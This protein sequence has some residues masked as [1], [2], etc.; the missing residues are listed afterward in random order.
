[1]CVFAIPTDTF[2]DGDDANLQV[3]VTLGFNGR[4]KQ[5]T[6]IPVHVAVTN[7]STAEFKGQLVLE[8]PDGEGIVVRFVD[9]HLQ[10]TVPP[11]TTVTRTA[12]VKIGRLPWNVEVSVVDDTSQQTVFKETLGRLDDGQLSTTDF[13]ILQIGSRLPL[14]ASR[15]QAELTGR[16]DLVEVAIQSQTSDYHK[17]PDRW[18]GY[19]AVDL[20]I[21]TTSAEELLEQLSVQQQQAIRQWIYQGGRMLLFAGQRGPEL[22]SDN[23]V[24]GSLIPGKIDRVI[25]NWNTSGIEK[26]GNAD[27]R[28]ILSRQPGSSL[29]LITPADGVVLLRDTQNAQA[30]HALIVHSARGLG[31][32]TFAAFDPDQEPFASWGATPVILNRL[33]I[34]SH[35]AERGNEQVGKGFKSSNAGFD[36]ISGQLRSSLD[37]FDGVT[38]TRFMWVAGLLGMFILVIGPLDYYILR[39]FKRLHWT[40]GTFPVAILIFSLIAVSMVSALRT[41]PPALNQIEIVDIDSLTQTVRGSNYATVYSPTIAAYSF[42]MSEF[43]D[44]MRSENHQVLA[45]WQGFPGAGLGGLGRASFQVL[46]DHHYEV[47][48]TDGQIRSVPVQHSGTR[49]LVARWSADSSLV[50]KSALVTE[51]AS[52]A[53]RGTLQNPFDFDL[54]EALILFDG[55]VY[56][57]GKVFTANSEVNVYDLSA[58]SQGIDNYFTRFQS[59]SRRQNHRVWRATDE[60]L[61]RVVKQM[62]FNQEIGGVRYTGLLHRYQS[63]LDLSHLLRLRRAVLVGKAGN[64]RG[65]TEFVSGSQQDAGAPMSSQVDR[66]YRVVLPVNME[67]RSNTLLN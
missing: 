45:C 27:E 25:T 54:D 49:S 17:L 59:G 58:D 9:R 36:D 40:W 67:A 3:E 41:S 15:L 53:L 14:S 51:P 29:S 44:S 39:R 56:P 47:D 28:L 23:E 46:I 55:R 20:L 4:F 32:V 5:G 34:N 38:P 16:P 57:L 31:A 64:R 13:L 37:R 50:A 22:S 60:S 6:W 35:F 11:T 24:L 2:A 8:S 52:G 12:Y 65:M 61:D 33:V 43:N 7:D 21:V 1:M 30:K 62:M 10:I 19:A 48:L 42:E 63:H 26:Y 66:Y 18:Y